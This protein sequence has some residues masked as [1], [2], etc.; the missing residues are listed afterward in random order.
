VEENFFP[1]VFSGAAQEQVLFN[2]EAGDRILFAECRILVAFDGD[3][4]DPTLELGDEDDPNGIMTSAEIAATVEGGYKSSAAADL[5][6]FPGEYL[7]TGEAGGRRQI[8]VTFT[9]AG[10]SGTE[11]QARFTLFVLKG[12]E[13]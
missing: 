8:L 13:R 3:T 7:V 12:G 2:L 4:G 1:T 10:Q 9:P 11:G 5:L 6:S